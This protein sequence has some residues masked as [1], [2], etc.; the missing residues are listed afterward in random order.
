MELIVM[1]CR[2]FQPSSAWHINERACVALRAEVGKPP[3]VPAVPA[4]PG[5]MVVPPAASPPAALN[6]KKRLRFR[7]AEKALL[8]HNVR[9]Y[10]F[11]LPLA[12]QRLGLPVGKH[13]FL[14]AQCAR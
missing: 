7:L 12:T 13:V 8:S 3:S 10:R 4:S 9:R 2:V 5:S 6:P 14:Y 1:S 11:A